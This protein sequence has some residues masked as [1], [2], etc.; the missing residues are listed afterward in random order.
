MF[1]FLLKKRVLQRGNRYFSS[2]LEKQ[3][4]PTNDNGKYIVNKIITYTPSIICVVGGFIF[5]HQNQKQYGIGWG[6]FGAILLL[7]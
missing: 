3:T 2:N 5:E 6:I 7:P 4:K 1:L